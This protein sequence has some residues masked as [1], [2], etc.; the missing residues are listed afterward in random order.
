MEYEDLTK[1]D[2]AWREYIFQCCQKSDQQQ[3]DSCT[4][5]QFVNGFM[6]L[7][8]RKF[9]TFQDEN[10]KVRC[11]ACKREIPTPSFLQDLINKIITMKGGEQL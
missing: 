10:G 9:E 7:W 2:N 3:M 4:P 5:D 11:R 1:I 6:K 8:H